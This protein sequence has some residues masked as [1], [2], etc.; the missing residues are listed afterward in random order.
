MNVTETGSD[1]EVGADGLQGLDNGQDVLGLSV[2]RVVVNVLVVDTVLLTTG[3]T[4]LHLEPLLHGGSALEV[5]SGSVDVVVDGLLG[6][7]DHVGGEE[8][9]AVLL[10]V[11]LI[12]VEHTV[13]PWQKLL[14]A[15]VGVEDNGDAVGRS[16]RANVVGSSDSASNRSGLVT[17]GNALAGE[18]SSTTLGGLQDDGRLGIAGSLE[19]GDDSRAGGYVDGRNGVL[20]LTGVLEQSEDIVADDDTGLAGQNV[21]STHFCCCCL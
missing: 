20:V 1:G 3:D 15:V 17:V 9:L 7:V 14:G 10:E 4:N 6:Q 21:L 19:S 5:G 8:R 16:D 13:Q 18:V 2:Q 12:G 11:L